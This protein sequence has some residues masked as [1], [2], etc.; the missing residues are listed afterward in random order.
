MKN[1]GEYPL[2]SKSTGEG[3]LAQAHKEPVKVG[4]NGQGPAPAGDI[5]SPVESGGTSG[6]GSKE[7]NS[8]AKNESPGPR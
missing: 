2:P 4:R 1:D 7:H 5:K 3:G 6:H 8:V